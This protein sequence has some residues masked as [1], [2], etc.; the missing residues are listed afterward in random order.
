MMSM[1][2]TERAGPG[3]RMTDPMLPRDHLLDMGE[4]RAAL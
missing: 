2:N 4:L 3:S 1:A